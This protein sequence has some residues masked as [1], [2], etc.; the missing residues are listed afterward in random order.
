MA[1]IVLSIVVGLIVNEFCEISPW[2]ARKLVRWAAFQRYADPDRAE[3][4]AEEWTALINDRP[5]K[6]FKLISAACFTLSAV[7]VSARRIADRLR[8][9]SPERTGD[10]PQ[11][12][13]PPRTP[14]EQLAD[15]Q[16]QL[17]ELNTLKRVRFDEVTLSGRTLSVGFTFSGEGALSADDGKADA[18]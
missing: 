14:A 2:C 15:M 18:T 11:G 6:L 13:D 4:R 12:A 10:L 1:A 9:S 7:I 3:I 16:R 17:T 8:R 5:G